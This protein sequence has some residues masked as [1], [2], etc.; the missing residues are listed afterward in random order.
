LPVLYSWR[1]IRP[2]LHP[3]DSQIS[4]TRMIP[5][6]CLSTIN[7]TAHFLKEI[8]TEPIEPDY[9]HIFNPPCCQSDIQPVNKFLNVCQLSFT[10]EMTIAIVVP[11]L[12]RIDI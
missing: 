6:D 9:A 3:P 2:G 4:L 10:W 1:L 7:I 11:K 12:N 5:G 8:I